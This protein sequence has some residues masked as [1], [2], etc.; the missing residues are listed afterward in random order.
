VTQDIYYDFAGNGPLLVTRKYTQCDLT[1]APD[2]NGTY[3]DNITL[4]QVTGKLVR[5]GPLKRDTHLRDVDTG[6][7][8]LTRGNTLEIVTPGQGKSALFIKLPGKFDAAFLSGND[9]LVVSGRTVVAYVAT[10][11]K[12]GLKRQLP[13]GS[14][15]TGFEQ[16]IVLY[17]KHGNIHVLRLAD[18]RD[19]ALTTVS[20][21]VGAKLDPFGLFYAYN[22]P[23]GG[24][25]PGRVAFVPFSAL[26]QLL[27]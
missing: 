8:L 5:I 16:G 13:A 12:P 23:K 7:L 6:R 26:T 15:I 19:R 17:T 10:T 4:Y 1:C 11:G 24:S 25:K 14:K 22:V 18:G 20:G 21:F 9:A 27:G 2:Y 3:Q